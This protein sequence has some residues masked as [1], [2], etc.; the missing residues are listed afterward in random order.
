MPKAKDP[1]RVA[2]SVKPRRVTHAHAI[3]KT[4]AL[5]EECA[6][7]VRPT[8]VGVPKRPGECTRDARAQRAAR[9]TEGAGNG[10]AFTVPVPLRHSCDAITLGVDPHP[11]PGAPHERI[12]VVG[13]PA[14]ADTTRQ[15]RVDGVPV[16]FRDSPDLNLLAVNSWRCWLWFEVRSAWRASSA[17]V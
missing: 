4:G 15:P 11:T 1:R 2:H 13:P 16:P 9:L 12:P 14:P 8:A 5:M 3:Y 10:A 6:R 17:A 7:G